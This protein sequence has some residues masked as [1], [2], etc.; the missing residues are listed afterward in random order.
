MESRRNKI[1][2]NLRTK[3]RRLERAIQVLENTYE[4]W[5]ELYLGA[6][7]PVF[8]ER[9]LDFA[10]E[11]NDRITRAKD[12]LDSIMERIRRLER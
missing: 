7:N 11:A 2:S 3:Q 12:A 8:E 10:R 5:Y 1:L 6:T 9:Y 4:E